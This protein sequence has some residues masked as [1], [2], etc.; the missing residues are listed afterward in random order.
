MS[1]S[2]DTIDIEKYTPAWGYVTICVMRNLK[3]DPDIIVLIPQMEKQDTSLSI[4]IGERYFIEY[5]QS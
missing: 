5:N 3:I 2:S 1:A 4:W